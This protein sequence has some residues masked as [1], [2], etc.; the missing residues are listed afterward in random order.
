MSSFLEV[1]PKLL[2]NEEFFI[3]IYFIYAKMFILM[4]I[5]HQ[6]SDLFSPDSDVVCD[7]GMSEPCLHKVPK[8]VIIVITCC[9]ILCRNVRDQVGVGSFLHFDGKHF[10]PFL[11]VEVGHSS[12]LGISNYWCPQVFSVCACF[13]PLVFRPEDTT[14]SA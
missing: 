13:S 11:F 5:P 12:C 3:R 7:K 1:V 10:L 2:E 4:Q 8:Q 14:P 6:L 9:H